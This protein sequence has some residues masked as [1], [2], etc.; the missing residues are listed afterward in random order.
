MKHFI[1]R[2]NEGIT[3][4][5]SCH[6]R[7]VFQ[8]H[9]KGIQYA[10]GLSKF[11]NYQNILLKDFGLHAKMLG[12][13][14]KSHAI[15]FAEKSGRPY[16]YLNSPKQSKEN[17][18]RDIMEKD[19]I[20]EGLI[21]VL[22]CVELAPA[23]D[24]FKNKKKQILEL[25]SKVRPC[26]HFYFYFNDRDFGLMYVRLQSWF[27]FKIQIGMNGH[28]YLARGMD[29]AGI[30]YQKVDNCFSSISDIKKAQ[31]IADK[32]TSLNWPNI[33]SKFGRLANPLISLKGK[34]NPGSYYWY[35]HQTEYA[36][37]TMF[38]D[39]KALSKIYPKL[40]HHAIQNF[41][42]GNVLKFLGKKCMEI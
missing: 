22:S 25:R 6:D 28:S 15:N 10:E 19:N 39:N 13:I 23:F 11:L 4:I 29:K 27:P 16:H 2:H 37:D 40:T 33:L 20:Q 38:K 8:G 34:I 41:D 42:S 24:I 1:N 32:I 26:S 5:I 18:A 14:I 12:G 3:G 30:E 31:K 36:T 7:I 35:S 17:F 21:C 9:L